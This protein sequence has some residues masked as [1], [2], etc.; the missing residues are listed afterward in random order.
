MTPSSCSTERPGR[1]RRSRHRRNGRAAAAAALIAGLLAAG[2]A[3]SNSDAQTSGTS[4]AAGASGA[5]GAAGGSGDGPVTL[6]VWSW[7]VEDTAAY[8]KIFDVYQSQNPGVTVNFK[9]F[10]ATEYNQILATGLSGSDGPDVPQVRSYGQL[11]ATLAAKSLVPLDD[12][13]DLAGWDPTIVASAKSKA[14]GKLYAVPFAQQSVQLYY[15]QDVFSANNLKP[16]TS[17]KEF[18]DACAKLKQAGVTPLAVGGKD[19]WTLPIVHESVAA[20]RFGGKE[21]AA[22]AAS[23]KKNFSDPNWTASIQTVADLKQYM[24][25]GVTGVPLT[26]AVTLFATGKA[27]I[28]PGGSYDLAMLKA[29]NPDL[30]L[31]VFQ[32]PVVDGAPAGAAPTTAGWADGNF[33]VNA[34]GKNIAAAKKLVKWMS[35]KEFGQL[36]VDEIKQVS[37]V[38]GVS[39]S[40]P[41]MQQMSDFYAKNPSPYFLLTD[42]RYGTPSGGELFSKGMVNVLLGKQSPAQVG[43][44][45]DKGIAAWFKPQQ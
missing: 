15:N 5:S 8:R 28:F 16:P 29:A 11:Q 7:R 3:P 36:V 40:D 13:L 42:F 45:M 1:D 12:T 35:T 41:L 32:M 4:P 22:A 44:D 37:A 30:K 34:K 17:W 14:D 6:T 24:P 10:K 19:D 21:F 25:D 43:T 20:T 26:D 33:G 39:F 9:A 27:A 31:G 2:C 18:L 23:G 38:P